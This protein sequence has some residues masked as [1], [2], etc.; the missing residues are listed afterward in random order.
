LARR[1][2]RPRLFLSGIFAGPA[3]PVL[4]VVGR[5]ARRELVA[6]AM[7]PRGHEQEA[8]PPVRVMAAKMC[9]IE[10][11]I[12]SDLLLGRCFSFETM[13]IPSSVRHCSIQRLLLVHGRTA[14]PPP[15]R[16]RPHTRAVVKRTPFSLGNYPEAVESA[17]RATSRSITRIALRDP[18][19]YPSASL[20]VGPGMPLAAFSSA[21][22]GEF[23][24]HTMPPQSVCL[25]HGGGRGTG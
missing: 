25:R 14:V 16:L 4:G 8:K 3:S 22:T 15:D 11:V 1:P 5:I 10:I 23:H 9:Q 2:P 12:Q 6:A 18:T 24:H 13:V 20:F 7:L 17:R 21:P 19:P